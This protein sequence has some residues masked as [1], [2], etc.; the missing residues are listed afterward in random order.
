MHK[1]KGQKFCYLPLA[2][3][4]RGPIVAPGGASNSQPCSKSGAAA[5][6]GGEKETE[7]ET[8]LLQLTRYGYLLQFFLCFYGCCIFDGHQRKWNRKTFLHCLRI[9]PALISQPSAF[10]ST[11]T[12]VYWPQTIFSKI[13]LF[14]KKKT[15]PQIVRTRT[16]IPSCTPGGP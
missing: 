8:R 15:G 2:L 12:F 10:L 6:G 16:R 14:F 13:Y 3:Q 1:K 7:R 4:K 5:G 9:F 11:K